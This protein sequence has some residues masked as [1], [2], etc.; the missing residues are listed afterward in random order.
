MNASNTEQTGKYFA[1]LRRFVNEHLIE[2]I[3]YTSKNGD[4]NPFNKPSLLKPGAEKVLHW[5]GC[6]FKLEDVTVIE[7]W[8]PSE[9][10]DEPFFFYRR[11]CTLY[12]ALGNPFGSAEG[13]ANS[14]EI[15]Y[16]YRSVNEEPIDKNSIVGVSTRRSREPKF[17]VEKAETTG[18]YAKPQAYWDE[19]ND[20]I[21]DGTAKLVRM[22]R[23]RWEGEGWEVSTTVW[24]VYNPDIYELFN[25]VLKMADKRALIAVVLIAAGMSEFFTQDIED[26]DTEEITPVGKKAAPRQAKATPTANGNQTDATFPHIGAAMQWAMDNDLFDSSAQAKVA[27]EK[28]MKESGKSYPEVSADIK[29]KLKP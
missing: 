27:I 5:I 15:K 11:R 10:G 22:K 19:F 6:S 29:A 3:D 21:A 7:H 9:P 16:R 14:R 8:N 24:R 20:A 26:I 2:G 12:D 25:T 13:S 17:A 4:D 23:G 1:E 28:I 18:Q